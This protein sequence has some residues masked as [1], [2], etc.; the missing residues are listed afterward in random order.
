MCDGF[1]LYMQD[2]TV[3][4]DFDVNQLKNMMTDL[5]EASIKSLKVEYNWFL[6][7]MADN[8]DVQGKCYLEIS[9]VF[10][11]NHTINY[12]DRLKTPYMLATMYELLRV[13]IEL[14]FGVLQCCKE[15]DIEVRGYT[16]PKG[17]PIAANYTWLNNNPALWKNPN[18]FDPENFFK[19]G[20][21]INQD[22]MATFSVGRRACVGES[23]AKVDMYIFFANWIKDFQIMMPDGVEPDFEPIPDTPYSKTYRIRMIPRH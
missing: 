9:S 21:L 8:Q 12:D 15:H 14:P 1:L 11:K 17:T 6:L 16:I 18:K 3:G 10:D 4:N 7:T 13:H 5:V 19:D 22:K 2:G 23:M 20:K